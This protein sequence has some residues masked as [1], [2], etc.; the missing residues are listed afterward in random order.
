MIAAWTSIFPSSRLFAV[1]PAIFY[2]ITAVAIYCLAF[3]SHAQCAH[4]HVQTPASVAPFF[5]VIRLAVWPS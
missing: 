1:D 3:H 2:A 5:G 4:Q